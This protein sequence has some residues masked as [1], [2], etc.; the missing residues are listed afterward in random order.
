MIQLQRILRKVRLATPVG[1]VAAS[2]VV[3]AQNSGIQP[4]AADQSAALS[5]TK[6]MA[7]PTPANTP[8]SSKL[9][10]ASKPGKGNANSGNGNSGNGTSSGPFQNGRPRAIGDLTYQGGTLV[11]TAQSHAIYITN[12]AVS[13]TTPACWGNPEQFLQ[14]L[15]GSDFIQITNQ[16][17]GQ[18]EVNQFTV[19]AQAILSFPLPATPLT[20]LDVLATV[21]AVAS[22]THQTGYNH[23][24]HVF[25]PL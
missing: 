21:H 9:P 19:G 23:I 8:A 2:F 22:A 5:A 17:T 24:Y 10:R 12:A 1:L 6:F 14:D 18:P 25:L 4:G 15:S 16:Y 20:D 3:Q 11:T 13:C 7:S